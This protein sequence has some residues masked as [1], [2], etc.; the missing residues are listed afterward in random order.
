MRLRLLALLA[1]AS[2]A[3]CHD[4][5][6]A[7]V[8]DPELTPAVDLQASLIDSVGAVRLEWSPYEG[9]V[10][11]GTYRL[12]RK[13]EG[14]EA[15]TTLL[16]STRVLAYVDSS[17]VPD[18]RYV[19]R[20]VVVNESGFEQPSVE[21]TA[22][23]YSLEAASD[24]E[25]V[26]DAI[27]GALVVSWRRYGSADFESYRVQRAELGESVATEVGS[28]A[29]RDDTL[30]VDSLAVAG[31]DYE[32]RV[33]VV[34]AGQQLQGGTRNARLQLPAVSIDSLSFDSATASARLA[35]TSYSGPRFAAYEIRRRT[36]QLA[37]VTVETVDDPAATT[38]VDTGLAGN[39]EYFYHIAVVTDRDERASGE[40]LS[41]AFHAYAGEWP[42]TV[43]ANEYVRLYWE[44]DALAVLLAGRRHLRLL[45]FRSDGTLIDET[46]LLE[47]DFLDLNPRSAS[48]VVQADG[49]RLVTV[50]MGGTL[51]TLAFDAAGRLDLSTTRP[52]FDGNLPPLS[53]E[54]ATV[55]SKVSLMSRFHYS[56]VFFDNVKASREGSPILDE[57]F[58][59]GPPTDWTW[60]ANF[61]SSF[62]NNVNEKDF[63]SGQLTANGHELGGRV[64]FA[65]FAQDGVS[66]D[67][68][69]G[70]DLLIRNGVAGM[71]IGDVLV[72]GTSK[73]EI[74]ID[75]VSQRAFLDWT[76]LPR[77]G[78]TQAQTLEEPLFVVPGTW[79]RLVLRVRDGHFESELTTPARWARVRDEDAR[80][81]SSARVEDF[82]VVTDGPE[83]T[84]STSRAR[85][86]S[87]A[88]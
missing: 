48:M 56:T 82:L 44:G 68:E 57:D 63:S 66:A 69:A 5:R 17:I 32:Y 73:F 21:R 81:S 11:I 22:G 35:W 42:L 6:R 51:G 52:L 36:A 37:E 8:M 29:S 79:M 10:A 61:R 67:F 74:Q 18:T 46:T 25:V 59:T 45:R 49:G 62:L 16:D 15:F 39:T 65:S 40:E 80:W 27:S 72:E 30:F 1:C 12:Q 75:A 83:A 4:A 2:L 24:I 3:A 86:G 28:S 33:V 20:V 71:Q 70:G 7:N 34:A 58:E 41:G 19:Y 13:V 43:E 47:G 88:L 14:R 50:S 55:R 85:G 23:P 64:L 31:V 76:H 84:A 87:R 9:T 26:A 54:E 53:A 60:G 38:H 78:V 77:D